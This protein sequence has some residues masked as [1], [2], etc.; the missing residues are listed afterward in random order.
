MLDQ[1]REG[2]S[3]VKPMAQTKDVSLILVSSVMCKGHLSPCDEANARKTVIFI[4]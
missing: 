3:E 1:G 2:N 4:G